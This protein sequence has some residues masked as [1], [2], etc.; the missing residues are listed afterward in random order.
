MLGA[1]V[2]PSEPTRQFDEQT[3]KKHPLDILLVEDSDTNRLVQRRILEQLGYEP[4]LAVDGR[5]ALD[6]LEA[7]E[8]FDLVLMDIQM[9]RMD[10][11]E[12]TRGIL[13]GL[14]EDEQPRIAALTAHTAETDRQRC[15]DAG[16]D[17]YL[18]KPIEIEE[19]IEVLTQGNPR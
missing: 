9:P 15:L 16:V 7:G 12:A 18:A 11:L 5:A 2:A 10:G 8:R 19:L 17:G 13:E 1:E 4:E 6:R 3:A 14:P